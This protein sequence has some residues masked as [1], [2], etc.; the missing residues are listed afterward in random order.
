MDTIPCKSR[1]ESL[2]TE[3]LVEI[4]KF[5]D[6]TKDVHSLMLTSKKLASVFQGSAHHIAKAHILR[7][8]GPNTG[9]Y[10][11]AVMAVE[12]E[13]VKCMDPVAIEQFFHTFIYRKEWP[14]NYFTMRAATITSSLVGTAERILDVGQK[15]LPGY[16]ANDQERPTVTETE[17]CI[18][19]ILMWVVEQN[20]LYLSV[21]DGELYATTSHAQKKWLPRYWDCF[22]TGE[23]YQAKQALWWINQHILR[24]WLD[25]GGELWKLILR[26]D[27][28]EALR[29]TGGAATALPSA[30]S[31]IQAPKSGCLFKGFR[32]KKS[33]DGIVKSLFAYFKYWYNEEVYDMFALR[34]MACGA[35]LFAEDLASRADQSSSKISRILRRRKKAGRG[36]SLEHERFDCDTMATSDETWNWKVGTLERLWEP[37]ALVLNMGPRWAEETR[38]WDRETLERRRHLLASETDEDDQSQSDDSS[39]LDSSALSESSLSSESSIFVSEEEDDE[40]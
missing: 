19:S 18:R 14:M 26:E 32:H 23:L 15:H 24:T 3:T 4:F 27:Q 1:L 20:L 29:S 33:F 39:A 22:S 36:Q 25:D 5:A 12:S 8:V 9:S 6:T 38:F 31:T 17:R 11:L 7:L 13:A 30:H 28:L 16:W 34:G 37:A 2:P 35:R 21:Y 40:A 10:K